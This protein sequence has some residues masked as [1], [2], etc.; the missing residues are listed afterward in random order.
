MKP[1]FLKIC[2]SNAFTKG[3][4]SPDGNAFDSNAN[5]VKALKYYYLILKK[6]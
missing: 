2:T 1:Y 4:G 5:H 6:E 3:H